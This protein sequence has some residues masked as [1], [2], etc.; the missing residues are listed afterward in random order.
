MQTR[1]S[2]KFK[3]Q[4]LS[5]VSSSVRFSVGGNGRVGLPMLVNRMLLNLLSAGLAEIFNQKD[6]CATTDFAGN[7]VEAADK[8]QS[9]GYAKF[10]GRRKSIH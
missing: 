1:Y 8:L 6:G 10:G 4:A 7:K 9:S 5:K 2:E 3:E